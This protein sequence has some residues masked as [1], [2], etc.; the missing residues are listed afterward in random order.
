MVKKG[1]IG[2]LSANEILPALKQLLNPLDPNSK[3][4]W[5]SHSRPHPRSSKTHL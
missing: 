3:E 1:N 2:Y 5:C 4:F